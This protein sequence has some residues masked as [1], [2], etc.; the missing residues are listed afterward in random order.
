MKK[1]LPMLALA[2]LTVMSV[3]CGGSK[4]MAKSD[5][6]EEISDLPSWYLNPPQDNSEF[7]YATS[8]AKSARKDMARQRAQ[9]QVQRELA[10][11]LGTKVE[12]LQ[13][14]FQE[15]V[16]SGNQTNY[17][18]AFTNA[19]KTITN[20]ELQGVQIQSIKFQ[21]ANNNTQFECYILGKLPVG[22]ARK[23]L[24]NALSK[25]EELYVKFK[26]SKAFDE[27]QGDISRIGEDN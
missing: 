21:A 4:D 11:K 25:E 24:E 20:Q 7:L 13:K 9:I 26:E 18:D 14:L 27:L 22:E 1:L 3:A 15:E 12:A 6:E 8:S 23:A 2:A 19:T 5:V 16:T 10:Q 17:A